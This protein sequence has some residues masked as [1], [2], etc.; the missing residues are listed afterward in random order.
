MVIQVVVLQVCQTRDSRVTQE[1]LMLG[2]TSIPRLERQREEIVFSEPTGQ[3]HFMKSG[4]I[5]DMSGRS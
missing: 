2:T 3:H 5:A 1:I 4:I